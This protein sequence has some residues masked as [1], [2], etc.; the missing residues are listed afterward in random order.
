MWSTCHVINMSCDQHVMWSTC[1]VINM[2][3]DQHVMWSTCHVINMAC[4]QHVMWLNLLTSAFHW[5]F[6]NLFSFISA[7]IICGL[8][9][10]T[11]F[12][13]HF[14]QMAPDWV[15]CSPDGSIE[16]IIHQMAP[17]WFNCSPDGSTE[18]VVHCFIENSMLSMSVWIGVANSIKLNLL[19]NI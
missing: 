1:H 5:N 7:W 14:H 13:V 16:L 10:F 15:N 9:L 8:I 11:N 2:S 4:D 17:V 6:F 19:T 18:L 12:N 3:C